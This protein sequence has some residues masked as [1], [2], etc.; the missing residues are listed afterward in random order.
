MM[1]VSSPR[2]SRFSSV[3]G[4]PVMVNFMFVQCG[5]D[6]VSNCERNDKS[7]IPEKQDV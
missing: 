3:G 5:I 6:N 1:S 2:M 7:M 4:S